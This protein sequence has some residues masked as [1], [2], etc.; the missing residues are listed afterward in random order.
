MTPG[1]NGRIWPRRMYQGWKPILWYSKG[2]HTAPRK[3]T[4][5]RVVSKPDKR[6]HHW[7]QD[8]GV[9]DH[10]T[11]LF[12]NRDDLVCDP[13]LGGG[14][15]AL[16]VL[17]NGRRFLGCDVDAEAIAK[18]QSRIDALDDY[19]RARRSAVLADA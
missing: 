12:S 2:P 9:F 19:R 10:L 3:M 13:F 15:T 18:T 17:A 7:G 16:A 5:D 14:T 1:A 11:R 6:F 4:E 8:L